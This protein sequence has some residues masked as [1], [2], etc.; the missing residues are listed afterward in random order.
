MRKSADRSVVGAALWR[1]LHGDWY[2]RSD[3]GSA[4]C[5]QKARY[6]GAAEWENIGA[7]KC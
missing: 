7:F 4:Y 5:E 6:A 1:V 3:R 2:Y